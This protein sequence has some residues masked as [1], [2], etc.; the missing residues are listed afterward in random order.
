MSLSPIPAAQELADYAN[1]A[2]YLAA[3]VRPRALAVIAETKNVT[4]ASELLAHSEAIATYLQVQNFGNE[5]GHAWSEVVLRAKMRLG[6]LLP[7]ESGGRGKR[8]QAPNSLSAPRR[9][10]YRQLASSPAKVVVDKLLAT[11]E[12]PV[13]ESMVRTHLKRKVAHTARSSERQARTIQIAQVPTHAEGPGWR[14]F[15]GEFQTA[16]ADLPDGSLDAI[17]TD[18]PYPAELLPLWGDL[19]QHAAR[20]LKPQGLLIALTGQILLPQVIER[21]SE[22]LNYGWI[23]VQPLPGTGQNSRIM[24]RHV[25]QTWKPWIVFSNG[26]W[27]S[28][29]I[30]WHEDTTPT[31]VAQKSYRWQQDAAPAAYLIEHLTEKG[32]LVCDP[33]TGTGSYGEAVVG[34]KREFVGCEADSERF[35]KA[36]ERLRN[37]SARHLV[38]VP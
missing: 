16:L 1:P 29:I 22:H 33:F 28:G 5:A 6:E 9:S 11:V 3:V 7:K 12:G 17:I 25:F 18:P 2:E 38:A 26:T 36:V 24:G 21:V 32:A 8:L 31:S 37:G 19:A 13:T 23:Y 34:L 15:S 14:M 10:Q 30:D 20:L 27:P 4:E 35:E